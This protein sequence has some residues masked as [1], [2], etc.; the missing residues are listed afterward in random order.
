MKPA[1]ILYGIPGSGK[2]TWIKQEAKARNY[3]LFRWNVRNDR[4]L[5]EGRE[6]LHAQVRSQEK[7]LIWIEG[8]DD[9]TQEAQAFLRRIL[10]TRSP[11]VTCILEVRDPSKLSAPVL[12]RCTLQR[13]PSETSYRKTMLEGK[14][15]QLGLLTK[16]E[17]VFPTSLE[18]LAAYKLQGKDPV[19]LLWHLVEH[20][21]NNPH[22]LEALRRWSSG[23]SPWL[24]A[25]W[26]LAH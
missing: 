21:K 25:A 4:S 17:D 13:Q 10:D 20:Q 11:D 6:V 7:T 14:A 8:A 24:Q 18:E 19:K 15:T 1:L 5:R 26:L 2:T 23:A 22:T 16:Q 9:L 3:R 12:S